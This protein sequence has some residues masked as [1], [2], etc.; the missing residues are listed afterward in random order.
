ML[1]LIKHAILATDLAI[2]FSNKAKLNELVQTESFIWSNTEHRLLIQA[3][4]MTASDLC[5]SAKP[6]EVD[7]IQLTVLYCNVEPMLQ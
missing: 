1:G 5:A 6:W 2:F 4:S 7:Q 3:I